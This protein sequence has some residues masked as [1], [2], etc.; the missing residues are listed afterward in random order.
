[1][2]HLDQLTHTLPSNLYCFLTICSTW[3]SF[4]KVKYFFFLLNHSSKSDWT[5]HKREVY[6]RSWQ[7]DSGVLKAKDTKCTDILCSE[8]RRPIICCYCGHNCINCGSNWQLRYHFVLQ[9]CAVL[10][11]VFRMS[12]GEAVELLFCPLL[13]R[14]CLLLGFLQLTWHPANPSGL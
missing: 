8:C 3:L 10:L 4:F 7:C 1:M 12:L 5:L 11:A 9:L 14:I 13:Q 6:C 2:W